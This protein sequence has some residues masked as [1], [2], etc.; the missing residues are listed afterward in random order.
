MDADGGCAADDGDAFG[1]ECFLYG[2]ADDGRKVY[3]VIESKDEIGHGAR[4]GARSKEQV[5]F[6]NFFRGGGGRRNGIIENERLVGDDVERRIDDTDVGKL[7]RI[8][9][10]RNACETIESVA[11]D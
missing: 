5:M 9:A 8:R 3:D 1:A 2:K 11:G 6:E 7:K 10:N 4:L